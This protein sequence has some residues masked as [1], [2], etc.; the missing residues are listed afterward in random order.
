MKKSMY[1]MFI[2]ASLSAILFLTSCSSDSSTDPG[3][4]TPADTTNPTVTLNLT[5]N[6]N[7]S[8]IYN[9]RVTANDDTDLYSLHLYVDGVQLEEKIVGIYSG[10]FFFQI[11]SMDYSEGNHSIYVRAFDAANNYADSDWKQVNMLFDFDPVNNGMIRVSVDNYQELDPLDLVGY[12]DPYFVF[13]IYDIDDVLL[14]QYT[15]SVYTDT[16]VINSAVYQDF[17]INDNLKQI[18]VVIQVWDDDG[19]TDDPVDYCPESGNYY[20]FTRTTNSGGV[21]LDWT[22]TYSGAN[23]GVG[24]D[25]CQITCSI[26]AQ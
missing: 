1:L 24:D 15:T 26:S 4:D 17:D 8:G 18:K 6:Q 21:M 16:N 19:S 13:K 20:I 2:I 3:D 23:D 10:D 22:V 7:I 12:G 11:N 9:I 25:D 14:D 5:T